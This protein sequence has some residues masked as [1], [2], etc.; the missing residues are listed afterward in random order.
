MVI[1]SVHRI[2]SIVTGTTARRLSFLVQVEQYHIRDPQEVIYRENTLAWK[3]RSINAEILYF[4][5]HLSNLSLTMKTSVQ[6]LTLYNYC[7]GFS[8][9][10]DISLD[11]CPTL[12]SICFPNR[13]LG[14]E[15]HAAKGSSLQFCSGLQVPNTVLY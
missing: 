5:L 15:I 7:P 14:I 9:L 11:L 12:C 4:Q 13:C 6:Y 3:N 1:A 10:G 2:R 8:S